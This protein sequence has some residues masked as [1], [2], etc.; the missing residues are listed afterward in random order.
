VTVTRH[1]IDR[2]Y[3]RGGRGDPLKVISGA[4]L[5]AASRGL[6]FEAAPGTYLAPI[7]QRGRPMCAVVGLK[8]PPEKPFSIS[9][10]TVLNEAM[11]LRS[12]GHLIGM[13]GS[14]EV[15]AA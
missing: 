7:R 6:L 11:A 3:Q 2:Y 5:D 9:V 13:F 4:V 1:A 10:Q 14:L 15:L 8:G 12:F